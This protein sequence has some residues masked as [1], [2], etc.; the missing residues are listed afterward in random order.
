MALGQG[1]VVLLDQ[2][3][4]LEQHTGPLQRRRLG[5]GRCRG[6]GSGHGRID[7]P[8]EASD[9]LAVAAPVA[10]LKTSWLRPLS[11]REIWPLMK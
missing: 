8:T 5:P 2:L 7:F 9:T 3:L 10:G 4:E 6:T 11:E 1:I